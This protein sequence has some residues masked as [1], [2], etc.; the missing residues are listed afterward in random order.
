MLDWVGAFVRRALRDDLM[1][2]LFHN[3]GR[4]SHVAQKYNDVDKRL[5]FY[6]SR[7]YIAKGR[8]GLYVIWSHNCA[9]SLWHIWKPVPWLMSTWSVIN[10]YYAF[11]V[12][13]A[14]NPVGFV[15]SKCVAKALCRIASVNFDDKRIWRLSYGFANRY[16]TKEIYTRRWL[17]SISLTLDHH[18]SQST[19]ICFRRWSGHIYES[20]SGYLK[21]QPCGSWAIT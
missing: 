11:I 4:K 7:P 20:K 9:L 21:S 10:L 13:Y 2:H 1:Q 17:I 14:L 19:Y 12:L 16:L 5:W 8:N 18:V 15:Y 3:K 6:R